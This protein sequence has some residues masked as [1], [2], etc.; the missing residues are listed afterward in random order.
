MTARLAAILP[1]LVGLAW[2][3]AHSGTRIAGT[4]K[5]TAD[6]QHVATVADGPMHA[7]SLVQT[8]GSN[9]NTGETDYMPGARVTNVETSDL[10]QGNGPHQGYITFASA[11][12]T[13]ISRWNGTVSTVLGADQRPVTTFKGKWTMV[14]GTGRYRTARATGTYEGRMDSAREYTVDWEGQMSGMAVASQ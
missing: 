5:L 7:L 4:V 8:R 2:L 12:D 11:A 1:V 9:T 13:T 3:P 14:A 10:Q 6:S